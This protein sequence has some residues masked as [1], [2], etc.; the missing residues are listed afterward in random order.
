MASTQGL[1]GGAGTLTIDGEVWN[2]DDIEPFPGG[3]KRETVIAQTGVVGFTE[4]PLQ[5]SFTAK[6]MNRTDKRL[7]E[8]MDKRSAT[9]ILRLNTGEVYTASEMWLTEL[10][11]LKTKEGNFDVKF[12]GVSIVKDIA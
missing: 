2:A 3:V 1:I 7:E 4:M 8:L 11:A 6:V 12:E 10:S 9:I 5:A